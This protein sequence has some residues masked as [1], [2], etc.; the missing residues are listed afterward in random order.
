MSKTTQV[1]DFKFAGAVVQRL[2]DGLNSKS[3]HYGWFCHGW[4]HILEQEAQSTLRP[5]FY[6]KTGKY[7]HGRCTT[8]TQNV[9]LIN[10]HVTIYGPHRVF[11]VP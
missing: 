11:I 4:S 3:A 5:T 6:W 1:R 2:N 10:R 9:S 8:C 7:I